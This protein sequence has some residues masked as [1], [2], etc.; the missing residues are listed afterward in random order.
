MKIFSA[1]CRGSS[2]PAA[3][4]DLKRIARRWL[5]DGLSC[6][7]A[8][9][10]VQ[11]YRTDLGSICTATIFRIE[12]DGTGFQTL[13]AFDLSNGASPYGSLVQSGATLY[14]M[15]RAG[16][17]TGRGTIFRIQTNGTGFE[18][19]HAFDV[20][21]GL[22]PYCSLL[23]SDSTLYGMAANDSGGSEGVGTTFQIGIG[24][25]GFRVLHSFSGPDG[26]YPHGSLIQ[27]G[28]TLYGMT[29]V[30]GEFADGTVFSLVVPEPSN[31]ALF[32]LALPLLI[33]RHLRP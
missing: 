16:G 9:S 29:T 1:L 28:S 6:C 20:E 32:V 7:Q 3:S 21:D 17:P 2:I 26:G 8:S 19:M 12:T 13:H 5:I 24:G 18:V 23:L 15:T 27:S 14:R 10:Y 33:G 4:T 25:T 30:G 22:N 31:L 11:G